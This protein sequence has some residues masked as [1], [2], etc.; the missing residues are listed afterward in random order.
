[1]GTRRVAQQHAPDRRNGAIRINR[2]QGWR[3][4]SYC[5]RRRHRGVNMPLLYPTAMRIW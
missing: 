1:M 5:E 4:Q 3:L 2:V